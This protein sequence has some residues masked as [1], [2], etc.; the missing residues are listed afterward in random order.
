MVVGFTT[1]SAVS[2]YQ[3]Y[4]CEFEPRSWRD[5]LDATLCDKVCHSFATEGRWFSPVTLVSPIN[6][7]DRHDITEILLKVALN[8]I[9]ITLLYIIYVKLITMTLR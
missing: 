8:I 2:A 4:S 3:H 5:V 6:K 9:T 1:T 7:T